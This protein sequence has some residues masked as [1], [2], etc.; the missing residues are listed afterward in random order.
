MS[1]V[2]HL[3][4]DLELIIPYLSF[5]EWNRL[6]MIDRDTY[7]HHERL[8]QSHFKKKW[9]SSS[10]PLNLT[11]EMLYKSLPP[12]DNIVSAICAY[13]ENSK[14]MT[15][16]YDLQSLHELANQK[17][18]DHVWVSIKFCL[19]FYH[20]KRRSIWKSL[21]EWWT[22]D[23]VSRNLDFYFSFRSSSDQWIIKRNTFYFEVEI[24][25]EPP[26]QKNPI[27]IIGFSTRE[28][29][30]SN[31]FD[32][33]LFGWDHGSIALHSDDSCLYHNHKYVGNIYIGQTR[34]VVIGCGMND[35]NL[36]FTTRGQLMYSFPYPKHLRILELFPVI[37]YNP[38]YRMRLNFGSQ[39]FLYSFL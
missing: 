26:A 9:V 39:P 6:L 36:F 16:C 19:K 12:S 23:L 7:H 5:H 1:N 11:G 32:L 4:L 30:W 18:D 27:I 2:L 38:S 24:I 10:C 29:F 37:Q 35:E 17:R 21:S 25:D 22:N 13:S 3:L 31:C 28:V 14:S 15:Y 20:E 33:S 8:L 34:P